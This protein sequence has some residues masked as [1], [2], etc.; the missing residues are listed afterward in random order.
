MWAKILLEKRWTANYSWIKQLPITCPNCV[1]PNNK[2]KWGKNFSIGKKEL[3]SWT[4]HCENCKT[5][6]EIFN[7]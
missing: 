3:L 2:L 4:S 1:D 5:D 7:D 6:F